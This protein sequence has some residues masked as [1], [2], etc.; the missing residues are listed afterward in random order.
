MK[1]KMAEKVLPSKPEDLKMIKDLQKQIGLLDYTLKKV[2][3]DVAAEK[4]CNF[5]LKAEMDEMKKNYFQE[6]MVLKSKD[7]LTMRLENG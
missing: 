6:L 2:Q 7:Q 3:G 1:S 5:S 4:K